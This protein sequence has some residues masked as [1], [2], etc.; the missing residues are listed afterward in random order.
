MDVD[1]PSL[2]TGGPSHGMAGYPH[3]HLYWTHLCYTSVHERLQ[4]CGV[5]VFST[6]MSQ[7]SP[8]EFKSISR[9]YKMFYQS[10]ILAF[11]AMECIFG[12]KGL[13]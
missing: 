13:P 4:V 3:P 2:Q 1:V 10:S 11:S 6:E 9:A 7:Q 5:Y 12:I 8:V